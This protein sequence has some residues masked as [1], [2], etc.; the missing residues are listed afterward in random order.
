MPA[1][2]RYLIRRTVALV[3]ALFVS[4]VATFLLVRMVPGDPARLRVKNPTPTNLA[5]INH[6]LG[7]DRPVP[8]QYV[9][10]LKNAL[11][12]GSLGESIVTGR[13]V[14]E[15]LA[16]TWPATVK[17]ALAA[18]AIA[19]V[20]GVG[21][22]LFGARH[23][24]TWKDTVASAIS[25]VGISVPVF[26]LGMLAILVFCLWLGWLPVSDHL[27]LPAAVLATI[28]AAF[29]ARV[30]RT[31]VGAALR[32][33]FIRTARAK[34]CHE[35]TV[36][37]RHAGRVACGP[38]VNMA[39]VQFGYLLGGAVLTETV[40]AWPGIGRYLASAVLARDYP[41]VQGALLVL[42]TLVIAVN[43]VADVG[44]HVLDPRL[45]QP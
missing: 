40:F 14:K 44:H 21:L 37:Y 42:V 27:L 41:A 8:V 33:D 35:P 23:A 5:A 25:L 45:R 10:F 26:W 7:L 30:T 3:A 28:P 29:L 13:E 4:S 18:M 16:R 15:D 32:K 2:A 19:T 17:L 20:S 39:G 34:G 24:G 6:R 31:T 38:V 11:G 36:L 9:L 12:A 22:G 43:F 1:M